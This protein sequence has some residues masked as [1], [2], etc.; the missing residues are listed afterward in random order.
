MSL[1]QEGPW[2]SLN[3]LVELMMNEPELKAIFVE[4]NIPTK[5]ATTTIGPDFL[6]VT[7]VRKEWL[8]VGDVVIPPKFIN[9]R[10]LD[11]HKKLILIGM[12]EKSSL[13]SKDKLRANDRGRGKAEFVVERTFK[14][15]GLHVIAR[16]L[17][18]YG[19][20]N[21]DGELI[22]FYMNGI[23]GT[24]EPKDIRTIG[25]MYESKKPHDR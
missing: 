18:K 23:F 25:K 16:R 3:A 7:E 15:D 13:F 8:D 14:R 4:S 2:S 1:K 12:T 21:P 19:K 6:Y 17:A 11:D 10:W 5:W 24:V 9:G 20:Y 22:D